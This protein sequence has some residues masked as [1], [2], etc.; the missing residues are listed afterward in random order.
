MPIFDY[1][2][3]VCHKVKEVIQKSSEQEKQECP[4]C[5]SLME[6]QIGQSN[7]K[8]TGVGVYKNNTH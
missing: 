1:K 6:K 7:F 4:V 5:N 2:C 3:P 8:L